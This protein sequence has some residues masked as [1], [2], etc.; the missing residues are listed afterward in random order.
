MKPTEWT[1][2]TLDR[3]PPSKDELQRELA[4]GLDI[5]A[6]GE[7]AG[8]SQ[9][10]NCLVDEHAA[11]VRRLVGILL[12]GNA[13]AARRAVR[14]TF[15]QAMFNLGSFRGRESVRCWLLGLA[16]QEAQ[17]EKRLLLWRRALQRLRKALPSPV[18]P[19]LTEDAESAE[20]PGVLGGE[21]ASVCPAPPAAPVEEADLLARW[22]MLSE[23]QRLALLLVYGFDLSLVELGN[24][25]GDMRR[26]RRQ[27]FQARLRLLSLPGKLHPGIV[28]VIQENLGQPLTAPET[29]HVQ[30]HLALCPAC[31]AA[32]DQLAGLHAELP[33]ALRQRFPG[34]EDQEA[35]APLI[36]AAVA[37]AQRGAAARS[38]RTPAP[39]PFIVRLAEVAVL[40]GVSLAVMLLGMRLSRNDTHLGRPMFEPVAQPTPTTITLQAQHVVTDTQR[41]SW[42]PPGIDEV[43]ADITPAFS[44]DGR[45]M[46][47]NHYAMKVQSQTNTSQV[48]LRDVQTGQ[49]LT[50][51]APPGS[52]DS[53]LL[54][55]MISSDGSRVVYMA[56]CQELS[57][58]C[59]NVYLYDRQSGETRLISSLPSGQPSAG[60]NWQPVISANGRYVVF[61]SSDGHLLAQPSPTCAKASS[62]RLCW[63]VYVMD[64]QSGALQRIPVGRLSAEGALTPSQRS[65]S[66][67]D[68]GRWLAL[69]ILQTDE[70][71]YE[72]Q[73]SY[74]C[75]VYLYD[76]QQE[77]YTPL[78]QSASGEPGNGPAS[79]AVITPDGRYVAFSSQAD[80]LTLYQ[81]GSHPGADI[82]VVDRQNGAVELVSQSVT[83][84]PGKGDSGDFFV[85]WQQDNTT[86]DLSADGR[87]VLFFSTQTDLAT[88]LPGE[89]VQ[90]CSTDMSPVACW[91]VYLRDRQAFQTQKVVDNSDTLFFY[92]LKLSANGRW[93]GLSY[94]DNQ[95]C[96]S[97]GQCGNISVYDTAQAMIFNPLNGDTL[98]NTGKR[99]EW[100]LLREVGNRDNLFRCAALSADGQTLVTGANNGE[101][102]IWNVSTGAPLQRLESV[103][104]SVTAL[105]ISPDGEKL[106]VSEGNGLV[107]LYW[108]ANGALLREL[109]SPSSNIFSLAFSPDGKMLAVGGM[110]Y[111]WTWDM[112]TE[113][114][115]ILDF[116]EYPHQQVNKL[117][118]SPDGR[119]AA[120]ALSSGLVY[121]YRANSGRLLA[122]LG[123][124]H[125]EPVM[126]VDFS[127]NGHFLASV[128]ADGRLNAWQLPRRGI[129]E[130]TLALTVEHSYGLSD[131]AF[132][133]GRMQALI[134]SYSWEV[135][136]WSVPEGEMLPAPMQFNSLPARSLA[137]SLTR[138]LLAMVLGEGGV[139][140]WRWNETP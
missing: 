87:Y 72:L 130:I 115:P 53:H 1:D 22:E 101:V 133:P 86:L 64:L 12:P 33:G 38:A 81:Y 14:R 58:D 131:V 39:L 89:I 31:Q 23:E 96:R 105:A 18:C 4:Y 132:I 30:A 97:V 10:A 73:Q 123:S 6:S 21:K 114:Y 65:I 84:Q 5:A 136:R 94:T 32:A 51:P 61:W 112:S 79:Q 19:A 59:V 83:D 42:F 56:A 24:V 7:L 41:D 85:D 124:H 140:I 17:H 93:A 92:N 66:I 125:G 135:R 26:A 111:A 20:S 118:F 98:A 76:L 122:R 107:R 126:G 52:S 15:E 49:S 68:D 25:L 99:P 77:Q 3:R 102:V 44:A 106:A 74:S 95:L 69:T 47:Y 63:D 138:R 119:L 45:W 91:F 128:G 50:L 28:Q 121:V 139:Q 70:M 48:V 129:Q 71:A 75:Q 29:D 127:T 54:W 82:F 34:Q 60:M 110:E 109:D 46:V 43:F 88:D 55:P 80:N 137:F 120:H 62:E 103:H 78:N 11:V 37:A 36:A 108:I 100:Q 116:Y 134:A 8:I 2:A 27:L 67:T 113:N 117:V 40:L 90:D 35:Q 9:L 57:S 104:L 13:P 16:L